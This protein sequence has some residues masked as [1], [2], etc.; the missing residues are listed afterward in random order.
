MT[1]LVLNNRARFAKD[2]W[3]TVY[4]AYNSELQIK[5][6]YNKSKTISL[7]LNEN[8]NC[9]PLLELLWQAILTRGTKYV[10][11]KQ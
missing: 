4:D 9:G 8:I 5:G 10:V 6:R 2:S 7:I 11:E 3:F 1:A